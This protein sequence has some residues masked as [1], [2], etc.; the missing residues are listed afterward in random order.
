M[1]VW[2]KLTERPSD[3]QL[4]M[5]AFLPS[6]HATAS[7]VPNHHP[8]ANQLW[9]GFSTAPRRTR[10]SPSRVEPVSAPP[11]QK[12]N[13]ARG[14]AATGIARR[15]RRPGTAV[16]GAAAEA[17]G[18]DIKS[19]AVW[20]KDR[21]GT[22]YVFRNKHEVLLYGTRGDMPGPQWQPE[23]VFKAKRRLHS[24]KPDEVRQ[25]IERMYPDF[26][27]TERLELFAVGDVPGWTTW[28]W[29]HER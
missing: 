18:F 25:A 9:K 11:K 26:G 5:I 10:L 23:S 16:E 29:R 8:K 1:I 4:Q 12:L 28:G 19:S 17:W 20:V 22:G 15:V 27:M 6:E 21:I 3:K 2:N 7:P 14:L 24:Q 13:V